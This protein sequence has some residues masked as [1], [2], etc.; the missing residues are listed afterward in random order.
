MP[1][2]TITRRFIV[3][4]MKVNYKR[5]C[6]YESPYNLQHDVR[7]RGLIYSNFYDYKGQ[8]A[9]RNY[10]GDFIII[11]E[12]AVPFNFT[13]QFNAPIPY[14]MTFD[15]LKQSII[16]AAAKESIMNL[17]STLQEELSVSLP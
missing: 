7:I 4:K 16:E 8:F 2:F 6:L 5:Q 12:C 11:T 14:T 15:L 1:N 9:E 13:Y 17:D 10:L 3:E